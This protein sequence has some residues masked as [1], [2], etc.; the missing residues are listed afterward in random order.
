MTLAAVKVCDACSNREGVIAL[1][2]EANVYQKVIQGKLIPS[3]SFHGEAWGLYF[4][5]TT[6]IEGKYPAKRQDVQVSLDEVFDE[7]R[8]RG[9]NH[10]DDKPIITLDDT[11]FLID[12]SHAM[13]V[14]GTDQE[15]V[16]MKSPCT[17]QIIHCPLLMRSALILTRPLVRED[18]LLYFRISAHCRS[19][20]CNSRHVLP[21]LASFCVLG[22]ATNL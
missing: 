9:V 1:R 7:V 5:A 17:F 2:N 12:F 21:L 3:L 10:G 19:Y 15:Y 4:L 14:F 20:L 6:F 22:S 13:I 16:E 18:P 11:L 8:E